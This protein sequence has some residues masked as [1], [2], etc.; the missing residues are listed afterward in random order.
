MTTFDIA[1]TPVPAGATWHALGTT[2]HL[3]V[4]DPRRLALAR[5]LG[6]RPRAVATRG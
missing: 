4:T 5:R 6:P 3:R 1:P 2:V